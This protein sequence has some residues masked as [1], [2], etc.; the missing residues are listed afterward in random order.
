MD[1]I[2]E[3][4]NSSFTLH[5]FPVII[6]AGAPRIS[7]F[8]LRMPMPHVLPYSRVGHQIMREFEDELNDWTLFWTLQGRYVKP[9]AYAPTAELISS[10]ALTKRD[11][12]RREEREAEKNDP[13]PQKNHLKSWMISFEPLEKRLLELCLQ[14][15]FFAKASEAFDVFDNMVTQFG[16]DW[17]VFPPSL[18]TSLK[19]WTL[20][21]TALK[22]KST[23]DWLM[24]LLVT[25]HDCL[26]EKFCAYFLMPRINMLGHM[27]PNKIDT[28]AKQL[29]SLLKGNQDKPIYMLSRYR[30]S[31]D[32]HV[33]QRKT[34]INRV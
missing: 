24:S 1:S 33:Y 6:A 3:E 15:Q 4:G 19:L 9:Q 25:F 13:L 18:T 2:A 28:L 12:R 14:N 16:E 17:N 26:K 21:R 34:E 5:M 30:T 7:G 27:E 22:N 8:N 31:I 29:Y 20:Y 11:K 23:I 32:I 10:G